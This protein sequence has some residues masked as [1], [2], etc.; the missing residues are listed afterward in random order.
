MENIRFLKFKFKI[1]FYIT[2][3]YYNN[4]VLIKYNQHNSMYT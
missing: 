1:S 2:T 4:D 3:Q